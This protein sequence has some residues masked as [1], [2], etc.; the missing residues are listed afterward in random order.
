[1]AA[2]GPNL[3]KLSQQVGN[4]E[5]FINT[6]KCIITLLSKDPVNFII[7]LLEFFFLEWIQYEIAYAFGTQEAT[8][9]PKPSFFKKLC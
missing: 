3:L 6:V 1:M 9:P 2:V 7:R 5:T 8:L 4:I